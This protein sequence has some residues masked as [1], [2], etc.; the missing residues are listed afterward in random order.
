MRVLMIGFGYSGRRFAA[1][2]NAS[3]ARSG[4]PPVEIAVVTKSRKVAEHRQY[5]SVA[6]ALAAFQPELVINASNDGEHARVLAELAGVELPLITEKPF[7]AP[8]QDAGQT[9]EA[10]RSSP[11]VALN[12]IE[13]YSPATQEL[14]KYIAANGLWAV[15]ADFRW[16][17]NRLDDP[18]PTVGI[19]SEVIHPL[20]LV[21]YTTGARGAY[22]LLSVAGF[23]SDYS[24][25]GDAVAETVNLTAKLGST[26]VT[27]YASFTHLD[28][29][30]CIEYTLLG[31]AGSRIYARCV[32]DTPL[33]DQDYL[34]IW[35]ADPDGE[36][37]IQ[38]QSYS[39]SADPQ[40]ATISKLTDFVEELVF[41]AVAPRYAGLDEAVALQLTLDHIDAALLTSPV[42]SYGDR[43]QRRQFDASNLERLG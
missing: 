32:Y 2:L 15:R 30:R 10:L 3:V 42:L 36:E 35:R 5:D 7:V 34:K 40:M 24:I 4:R 11:R 43:A 39:G 12:L 6:E 41:G 25:S 28:R 19:V 37:V 22:E 18:R 29:S 23:R 26:S 38:E 17:K 8:G 20:D 21:A 16:A 1:A 31:Q 33:W 27:G 14:R 9:A 13:R